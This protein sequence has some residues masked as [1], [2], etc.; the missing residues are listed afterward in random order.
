MICAESVEGRSDHFRN[1][2]ATGAQLNRACPEAMEQ[3]ASSTSERE[4][5]SAAYPT[6]SRASPGEGPLHTQQPIST[7]PPGSVESSWPRCKPRAGGI[8]RLKP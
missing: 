8:P 1:T 6:K 2:I 3:A 4:S 5:V 7:N